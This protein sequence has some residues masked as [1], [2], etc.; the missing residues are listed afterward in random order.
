MNNTGKVIFVWGI[1]LLVGW[2][3]PYFFPTVLV[4]ST[5]T[6]LIFW[7]IVVVA[8]LAAAILWLPNALQNKTFQLW[9]IILIIGMLENFLVQVDV[10]P[11]SLAMLSFNH[12]W[13][14]LAGIGFL[15]TTKTWKIPG[16]IPIFFWAGILNLALFVLLILKAPLGVDYPLSSDIFSA[17]WLLMGLIQ[18]GPLII[19]GWLNYNLP[20]K[21]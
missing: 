6:A 5:L 10:L 2:L 7:T 1:L 8:A 12:L 4:S 11:R 19:D 21:A 16:S 13:L 9:A 15:L 18:G 14:L 17:R 3:G 20:K